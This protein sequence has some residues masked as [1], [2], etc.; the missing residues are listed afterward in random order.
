MYS[1]I[2]ITHVICMV[3]S[4]ALMSGALVLGMLRQASGVKAAQFGMAATSIGFITGLLLLIEAPLL[5]QCA[6]LT[7]YVAVVS[8]LY[9]FGFGFGDIK[10][11]RLIRS[12]R[13]LN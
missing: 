6:K 12:A 10:K 1:I 9:T 13:N 7:A 2:I 3:A 4:I 11:A 8:V 5:L